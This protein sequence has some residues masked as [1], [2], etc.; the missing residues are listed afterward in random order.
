MTGLLERALGAANRASRH[1]G[2][3]FDPATA[4][5]PPSGAR[6]N[7][8]H[9]GVMLPG[10]PEPHRAFG[11]MAVVGTPGVS[12]FA[13]DWAITTTPRDTAYLVSAT[14]SMTRDTFGAYSVA[15]SCAFD[16]QG[17]SLRFGDDLTIEGEYPHFTLHR[18]NGEVTVDLGIIATDTVT[19][20]VDVPG[21]YEH[22]SLLCDYTGRI[23][24]DGVITPISGH[25]TLEYA[26]GT[27]P[28]A[29]PRRLAQ[30]VSIPARTF[31]YQVLAVDAS[32]QLLLT[33]VRGPRR[34][35]IL[36][37]AYLRTREGSRR[38]DA[39]RFAV[40]SRRA[41]PAVTPDGRPMPMVHEFTWNVGQDRGRRIGL[42]CMANDD[43]AYGL[44]AGFVGSFEYSGQVDG[45]DVAGTGYIE[46]ID[47]T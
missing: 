16:P 17:R 5:G 20:F 27:G 37:T 12:I 40:T 24:H 32:R 23:V 18:D 26:R 7:W 38:L 31:T 28:N 47:L 30:R 35:P 15:R 42:D 46:Y 33:E 44:G 14:G 6:W 29:L 11:V 9:Y 4:F 22:W 36:R 3:A 39:A 10:L 8:C 21:V 41:E 43:W 19:W 25:C 13:N 1:D 34:T 2:R 45:E